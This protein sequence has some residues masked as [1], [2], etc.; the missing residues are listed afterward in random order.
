MNTQNATLGRIAKLLNLAGDAAA[1][2][3]EIVNA[4]KKV[5]N[6]ARA[7]GKLLGDFVVAFGS[8]CDCTNENTPTNEYAAN[9]LRATETIRNIYDQEVEAL[10]QRYNQ[11]IA[12]LHKQ[13]T[14]LRQSLIT[15]LRRQKDEAHSLHQTNAPSAPSVEAHDRALDC[16]EEPEVCHS[17]ENTDPISPPSH[18]APGLSDRQ[19][20]A[21][22]AY[23]SLGLGKAALARRM[24]AI[25]GRMVTIA[26]VTMFALMRWS[27]KNGRRYAMWEASAPT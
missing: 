24:A 9:F 20:K 13:N 16:L 27:P 26:E 18:D 1:S 23:S 3:A 8:D 4:M 11:D 14:R 2:D 21:F 5:A 17:L 7:S 25:L 12:K 19:W 22:A 10:R 15:R 6:V